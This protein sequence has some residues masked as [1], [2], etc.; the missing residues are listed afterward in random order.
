MSSEGAAYFLDSLESSPGVREPAGCGTEV[1][2]GLLDTVQ[3][4]EDAHQGPTETAIPN[5][6]HSDDLLL[7]QVQQGDEARI[8]SRVLR[9]KPGRDLPPKLATPRNLLDACITPRISRPSFT[10]RSQR[11]A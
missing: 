11:A 9:A 3:S 6:V 1:P 10:T 2:S 4:P 5:F 8:R 7:E